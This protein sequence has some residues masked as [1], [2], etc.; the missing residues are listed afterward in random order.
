M[1]SEY[2]GKDGGD[3]K[4]GGEFEGGEGRGLK[5]GSGGNNRSLLSR[6]FRGGSGKKSRN[7]RKDGKNV[8]EGEGSEK[9]GDGNKGGRKKSKR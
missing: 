7:R 3:I 2:K 6:K 5:S 4:E 1:N 8:S 9:R